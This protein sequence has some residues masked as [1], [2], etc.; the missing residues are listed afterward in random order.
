MFIVF[1]AVLKYTSMKFFIFGI[2][3]LSIFTGCGKLQDIKP[4]LQGQAT[5]TT[6][7][8]KTSDT[9]TLHQVGFNISDQKVITSV[10]GDT[11]TMVYNENISLL[12]LAQG[13]DESW[14]VHLF[15]DFSDSV[16]GAFNYT[17]TDPAGYVAV[18]WVDDNLNNIGAA[19]TISDTL[20]NGQKMINIHVQR[21]FT[22][23][24][25]YTDGPSATS[26]QDLLLSKTT[27]SIKF[28]SYIYFAAGNYPTSTISAKADYIK[29]PLN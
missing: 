7:S 20:V 16:L 24:K 1:I 11:L 3:I 29:K 25:I 10:S 6:I 21:P 17:T 4:T 14:A 13:Y 26:E 8:T 12:I 22:F 15:E 2:T 5:T 28:S 19:K 9:L 23:S 18:D 27:D